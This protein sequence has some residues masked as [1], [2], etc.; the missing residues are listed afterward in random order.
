MWNTDQEKL[1][2]IRTIVW[3]TLD[4]LGQTGLDQARLEACYNRVAFQL[5]DRESG[6]LPRSLNEALTMLDTWLY[7]GDP[8]QALT[9][10]NVL[11]SLRQKLQTEYYED[12]MQ[13][14]LLPSETSVTAVLVP[15]S[16]LGAAHAQAEAERLQT[17]QAG[18][19]RRSW[20]SWWWTCC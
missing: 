2:A 18:W 15:S 16:T 1:P 5:R 10:D 20:G 13:A 17:E 8:A 11:A 7:D 4:R 9:A 3:Q 12:L 19:E 6:G 14:L